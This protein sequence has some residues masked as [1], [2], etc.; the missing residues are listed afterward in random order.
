MSFDRGRDTTG[1]ARRKLSDAD[2]AEIDATLPDGSGAWLTG[3]K[4][5]LPALRGRP[6]QPG[7]YR[8][9]ITR[10]PDS[11]TGEAA[12]P[13]DAYRAALAQVPA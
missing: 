2:V 13:I 1:W 5:A 7:W 10:Y 8:A 6:A 12:S 11:W 4:P 3:V 9:T